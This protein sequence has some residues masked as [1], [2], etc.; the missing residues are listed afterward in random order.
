MTHTIAE[1]ARIMGMDKGKLRRFAHYHGI[2]F[3][4]KYGDKMK[5]SKRILNELYSKYQITDDTNI[6]DIKDIMSVED[7]AK[8]EL[9]FK[10]PN[11]KPLEVIEGGKNGISN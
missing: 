7:Y 11:G 2:S 3:K 6:F 10:Y 4:K 1:A 9:A 5:I 8:W